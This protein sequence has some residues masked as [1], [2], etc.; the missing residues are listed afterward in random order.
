MVYVCVCLWANVSLLLCDLLRCFKTGHKPRRPGT[1]ESN[2]YRLILLFTIRSVL[3][4]LTQQ[5]ITAQKDAYRCHTQSLL[6]THLF[7]K[8][9]RRVFPLKPVL[10]C[11]CLKCARLYHRYL[12]LHFKHVVGKWSHCMYKHFYGNFYVCVTS[13]VLWKPVSWTSSV[14]AFIDFTVLLYYIL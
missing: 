8:N 2:G 7:S 5:L 3:Q 11:V 12:R 14:A 10:E 4:N 13:S 1:F 6:S 9:D